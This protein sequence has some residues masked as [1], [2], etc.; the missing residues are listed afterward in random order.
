MWG[1]SGEGSPRILL[2]GGIQSG[3]SGTA[4]ATLAPAP[5][6]S[7]CFRGLPRRSPEMQ[8]Q[9]ILLSLQIQLSSAVGRPR[10]YSRSNGTGS[11]YWRTSRCVHIHADTEPHTFTPNRLRQDLIQTHTFTLTDPHTCLHTSPHMLTPTHTHTQITKLHTSTSQDS[12]L[13]YLPLS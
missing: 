3:P 2:G 10:S 13:L 11:N 6:V 8:N 1:Y 12:T 5:W 4:G 9:A 7:L